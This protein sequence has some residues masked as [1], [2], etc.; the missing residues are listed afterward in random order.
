MHEDEFNIKSSVLC[1]LR[2]EKYNEEDYLAPVVLVNRNVGLFIAK[3]LGIL[4]K[5]AYIHQAVSKGD[6]LVAFSKKPGHDRLAEEFSENLKVFKKS[7]RFRR[8]LEKYGQ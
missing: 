2:E 7:Y 5:V 6:N 1:D 8:I 4:D 3:K